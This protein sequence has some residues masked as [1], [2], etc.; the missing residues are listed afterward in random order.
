MTYICIGEKVAPFGTVK[1]VA[2]I[3]L[4]MAVAVLLGVGSVVAQERCVVSGRVADTNTGEA[5]LGAVV[6]VVAQ[7]STAF[8]ICSVV[9]EEVRPHAVKA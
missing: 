7:S 4:C 5:V 1:R 6:E 9:V 2:K 3:W 8:S